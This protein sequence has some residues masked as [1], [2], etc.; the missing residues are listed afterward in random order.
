MVIA[1]SPPIATGIHNGFFLHKLFVLRGVFSVSS[2]FVL[3]WVSGGCDLNVGLL[4]PPET[5]VDDCAVDHGDPETKDKN[6]IN[7][8]C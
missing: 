1:Q 8:N 2:E 4:L 7:D 5:V 6:S 3:K